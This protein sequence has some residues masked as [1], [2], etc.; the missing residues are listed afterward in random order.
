MASFSYGLEDNRLLAFSVCLSSMSLPNPTSLRDVALAKRRKLTDKITLY[1]TF[2]ALLHFTLDFSQGLYESATFDGIIATVVFTCFALNRLGYHLTAKV[3]VFLSLNLLL[4]IYASLVP[5]EIGVF[6]F[7]FP[8]MAISGAVF[9]PEEKKSRF[10]FILLP[11][12]VLVFL[13]VTDFRLLEAYAFA[14]PEGG[15]DLFFM[16]NVFSSGFLMTLGINYMITFNEAAELE[17]QKLAEQVDAKNKDLER[18]N[19]E[20]DRFLYSTSHDLR[21]PLSS[22]K[23]LINVAK[24]DTSDSKM[25]SYFGKMIERIEKLEDFIKDI[26]DY[27]K[28]TRTDLRME[29]VRLEALVNEVNENLKYVEGAQDIHFSYKQ[30]FDHPV[31]VDKTRLLIVL[32]NL[33]ANAIKYH[34]FTKQDRWI[35]VTVSSQSHLVTVTVADN[36]QGIGE[37]HRER[38]FDMFYRGTVQSGGSGLGLFIVKQAVEKL[39]GSIKVESALGKGSSFAVSFPVS[40]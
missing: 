20:L 9:G 5:K 39:N 6:L 31:T 17:L 1:G 24:Y 26:I 36:G 33:L 14:Q 4:A 15:T 37:E 40:E 34:D 29:K 3:V 2:F 38:I 11:F 13:F 10:V 8:L 22:I 25:L 27:S 28:N 19:A 23:G 7:Y 30:D 21:S 16:I 12:L 18:T 32:H 35:R